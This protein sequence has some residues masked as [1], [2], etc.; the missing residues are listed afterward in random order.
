MD[1]EQEDAV[2]KEG[3]KKMRKDGWREQVREEGTEGGRVFQNP[4]FQYVHSRNLFPCLSNTL[5][6]FPLF[7][8]S[9]EEATLTKLMYKFLRFIKNQFGPLC[10]KLS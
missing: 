8:V 9:V 2:W 3:R 1:D 4:E 10:L 5:G 6:K 7:C